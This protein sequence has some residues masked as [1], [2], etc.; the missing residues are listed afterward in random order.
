MSALH[1]A[2]IVVLV[3]QISSILFAFIG[4]PLIL[5]RNSR[6][7]HRQLAERDAARAADSARE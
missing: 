3:M 5:R 2:R 4:F 1:V 7:F 6:R